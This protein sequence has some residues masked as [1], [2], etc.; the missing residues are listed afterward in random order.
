MDS[1]NNKCLY[2]NRMDAYDEYEYKFDISKMLIDRG[3]SVNITDKH[4]IT[5]LHN[6]CKS[7]FMIK[8][9]KLLIDNGADINAVDDYGITPLNYACASPYYIRYETSDIVRD[10]IMLCKKVNNVVENEDV[11][12]VINTLIDRGADINF[13]DKYGRT[14]LHYAA[15]SYHVKIVES[16]INHGSNLLAVDNKGNSLLHYASNNYSCLEIINYLITKGINV[17]TRNILGKTPLFYGIYI[18]E[19]VTLLL[20]NGASVNILDYNNKTP[21]NNEYIQNLPVTHSMYK[22]YLKSLECVAKFVVLEGNAIKDLPYFNNVKIL[23]SFE[24]INHLKEICEEE[25]ETMKIVKINSVYNI[26]DILYSKNMKVNR[27]I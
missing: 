18:P 25:L 15:V 6:A 7:I 20:H 8:T 11:D 12:V 10:K 13:I 23:N 17:N 1:I 21:L 14:P 19:I 16:L 4:K 9:I 22:M 3:A 5:P 26:Y 24:N 27:F 2:C